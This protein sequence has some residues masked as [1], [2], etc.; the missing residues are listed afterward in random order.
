MKETE[1][2]DGRILIT[3]APGIALIKNDHMANVVSTTDFWGEYTLAM[4]K[5]LAYTMLK[6]CR[7]G[8]LLFII[9]NSASR[10]IA[11]QTDTIHKTNL[12]IPLSNQNANAF[13]KRAQAPQNYLPDDLR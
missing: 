5:I 1:A 11:Q 7:I 8:F 12:S 2:P 10:L 4:R 9:L 13:F 3:F 6:I